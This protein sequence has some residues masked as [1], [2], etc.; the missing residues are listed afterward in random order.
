MSEE[1]KKKTRY[2]EGTHKRFHQPTRQ[3]HTYIPTGD[4]KGV[5]IEESP[6][7]SKKE[8]AEKNKK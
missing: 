7:L 4:K 5:I 6:P 8:E 3:V 2:P 1:I